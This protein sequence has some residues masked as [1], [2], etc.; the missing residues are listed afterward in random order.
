MYESDEQAIR[1]TPGYSKDHRPDL[2]QA[3]LELLVSQDGGGPLVS[4]S[5]DGNASDTAIFKERAEALLTT[6]ARSDTCAG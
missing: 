3:V 4:K 1:I 2:K 5:W 6:F